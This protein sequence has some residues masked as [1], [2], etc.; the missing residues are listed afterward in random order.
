ML[1]EHLCLDPDGALSVDVSC[2]GAALSIS[3]AADGG[4]AIA[5]VVGDE[6]GST[7]VMVP[8]SLFAALRPLVPE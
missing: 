2:D 8:P 7:T 5:W 3:I 6:V 1:S 4:G